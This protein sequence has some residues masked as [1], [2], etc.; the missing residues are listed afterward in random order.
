MIKNKYNLFCN[1]SPLVVSIS[2]SGQSFPPLR[3]G[4]STGLNLYLDPDWSGWLQA[5]QSPT[6][7]GRETVKQKSVNYQNALNSVFKQ[8]SKP[9][10]KLFRE[11]DIEV[12]I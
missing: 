2:S 3:A 7:H 11:H 12:K 5:V 6:I 4:R 8:T 10:N 9:G 1:N